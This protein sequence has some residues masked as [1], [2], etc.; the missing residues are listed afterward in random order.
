[1]CSYSTLTK[2]IYSKNVFSLQQEVLWG[3]DR[4][5][6][7]LAGL[8]HWDAVVCCN[9]WNNLFHLRIPH[10]RWQPVEVIFIKNSSLFCWSFRCHCFV[11]YYF[12]TNVIVLFCG[13]LLLFHCSKEICS[14]EVGGNIVMCPLCDKKC[15]YWKLNSTCNSS[16]VRHPGFMTEWFLV[17]MNCSLYN[18]WHLKGGCS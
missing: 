2:R 18:M 7:C 15:G 13:K 6:F 8:L 16:W 4:Y 9:S 11:R 3:E 12:I 14:E 1:M 17:I 5:L 10:L